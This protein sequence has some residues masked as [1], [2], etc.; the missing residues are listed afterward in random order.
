MG[1]VSNPVTSD[2][3]P[4]LWVE[5]L[6]LLE[7][8]TAEQPLREIPLNRGL[9]LIVSPP[10]T[11][12]PGH[13][14]GKTAFCQL[15]RFVL[16]D[17]LWSEGSTLRDE[18]LQSRELKDGAVAARVHIGGE[19]WTVLKPW[20]H[21]K[22]YRASR[23]AS[24]RQLA[25]SEVEND[26]S[27][28]Q[29]ALRRHLVEV[30]PVQ[31]L[32]GSKQVIEWHQILAWCSRDQN[33]RYQSYFQWRAEGVG[34]TQ[35]AKSPV[36]LMQIVL[37]LLRDAGTLRDLEKSAK[38]ADELKTKLHELRDEPERLLKHVRRQL[39][40]RLSTSDAIPF[41]QDGLYEHPN[42][43]AIARQ[44]HEAYQQEQQAID[45]ERQRLAAERQSCVEK[46]APLKS[47]IDLVTNEV[48]QHDALIAGDSK[49]VDELRNEAS[50]LQQS[51]PTKCDAGNRLLQDCRY[52]IER[53]EQTQIDRTQR[54]TQHQRSKES[55]E[56]DAAA[57]RGRLAEL[58]AEVMPIDAH[59]AEIDQSVAELDTRYAQSLS[60]SQLLSDAIDDYDHYESVV[61]GRT[62]W[63][64]FAEVERKLDAAQQRHAQLRLQ[65]E[66]E[67][68]A[69][70]ERRGII[71][72]AMQAVTRTL[73][74]FIWG[75]F[76]DSEQHRNRPFQMGPMHST[77]FGVLEILAGD[78]A[79]L[80]DSSSEQSFHPGFLLHDSPREAEMSEALF[81]ALLKHVASQTRA[82]FQ[83][84]VT[85]STQPDTAFS[86]FVR[87]DLASDNDEGLLL[88]RRIGVHQAPIP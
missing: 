12:S 16:E 35:P 29:E 51:L 71:S 52:V 81:W 84:I 3:R 57:L 10:R 88:R 46:R 65:S 8:L 45:T 62:Q 4:R 34:F 39:N 76:N 87:L 23:T 18:L 6:W 44:R 38:E 63:A 25:V 1:N 13:G 22:H 2:I 48:A 17:P 64:V 31:N 56:R 58:K 59:L 11:D 61:S 55:L 86:P 82:P 30:L 40:R 21:Q 85:T 19:T 5:T 66:K 43:I 15:L 9:N 72:G 60:A 74:S 68:E 41:R 79:C 42:L 37:G 33:A 78:V 26:F 75:V 32:P 20:Q 67:R 50:S 49:R 28:Y 80:I 14:V 24:W 54:I 36:A 53:V 7:S 83:Y 77:T 69:T 27:G 70:G 73:P 47:R